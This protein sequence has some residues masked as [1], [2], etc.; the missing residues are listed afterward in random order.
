MYLS[1]WQQIQCTSLD[2]LPLLSLY[3]FLFF[4]HD[5][6]HLHL[7]LKSQTYLFPDS[8]V[9]SD[10][11]LGPAYQ[12]CLTDAHCLK[13]TLRVCHKIG[14]DWI[15]R[16]LKRLTK[17]LFLNSS[18]VKVCW[19]LNCHYS[20]SFFTPLQVQ[21]YISST[22]Q[23]LLVHRVIVLQFVKADADPPPPRPAPACSCS[24]RYTTQTQPR[25]CAAPSWPGPADTC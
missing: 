18:L 16:L 15:Q 17:H 12:W 7:T 11:L 13:V 5:H 9:T 8:F 14:F 25:S 20:V 23:P 1:I 6:L 21:V 3:W 19:L 24:P 2:S 10:C 22:N 4:F